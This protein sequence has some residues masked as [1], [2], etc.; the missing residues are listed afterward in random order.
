MFLYRCTDRVIARCIGRHGDRDS[1][2]SG[3]GFGVEGVG[4]G[5]CVDV[6]LG[7]EVGLGVGVELRVVVGVLIMLGV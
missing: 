1:R 5:L 3:Q 6:G 2:R 4:I 7:V